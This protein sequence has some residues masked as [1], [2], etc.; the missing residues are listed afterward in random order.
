MPESATGRRPHLLHDDLVDWPV[1][2][3]RERSLILRVLADAPSKRVLDL[4]CGAGRHARMLARE[5]YEVV[6][7]DASERALERA[8]NKPVPAGLEFLPGEIGAVEGSVRGHFGAALCL[9]NTLP[10]LLSPESLARMFIG[11][12]RRLIPGA[13]FLFQVLNYDRVFETGERALPVGLVPSKDGELV[14]LELVEPAD[15]GIVV[16]TT[17]VLRHQPMAIPAIEIVDTRVMQLMGWTREQLETM[18]DV[19]RWQIREI[20]GGM[21][22]ADYDRRTSRELVMVVG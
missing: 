19:V 14:V 10:H 7:I 5:G 6:A 3:D 11:L 18:A 16:H 22:E 21:D 17:S 15:D 9:G 1:R 8:K 4:G 12:K 13:P 20:Y 2:L